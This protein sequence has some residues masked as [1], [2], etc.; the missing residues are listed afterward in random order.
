MRITEIP[1]FKD[2]K[3]LLLLESTMT[4]EEAARQMKKFNYG[5][6]VVVDNKKLS[7]IFTERDLLIKVAAEGKD[8]KSLLVADVMTTNVKTANLDDEVYDSMRRM[9]QGKFRHL[10]VIDDKGS[11]IGMLSQGDFVAATW[12][13]LFNQLK[14]QTK[15]SLLSNT[16]IWML[17]FSLIAYISLM[18]ILIRN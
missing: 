4:V 1:E 2:K 15:I 3:Q 13:Q 10:P 6:A 14:S 5:A 12:P 8:Y 17:V 9:T 7:G 18:Y 16:Q 11:V